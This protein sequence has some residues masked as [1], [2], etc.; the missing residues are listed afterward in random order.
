MHSSIRLEKAR[1]PPC[2]LLHVLERPR[3]ARLICVHPQRLRRPRA[4]A[5]LGNRSEI[6]TKHT[7]LLLKFG[8]NLVASGLGEAIASQS[9]REDVEVYM[10]HGLTRRATV[11]RDRIHPKSLAKIYIKKGREGEE[12]GGSVIVSHLTR[13]GEPIGLV[14]ALD[15]AAD[16]LDGAHELREFVRAEV[17]EAWDG[18]RRAHEHV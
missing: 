18:A 17:G 2:F 11:L 16:A 5:R 6:L 13:N 9:P 14:C 7:L 3:I 1:Q 15:D 8:I 12:S 10:R 4:G